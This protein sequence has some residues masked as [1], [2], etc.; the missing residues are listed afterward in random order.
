MV[1]RRV[2][3][4]CRIGVRQHERSPSPPA[5]RQSRSA[6]QG[7][8][9][10]SDL[11]GFAFGDP[12]GPPRIGRA[13]SFDSSRGGRVRRRTEHGGRG[14]RAARG[15]GLPSLPRR[16]RNA[17]RRHR[18]GAAVSPG[19]KDFPAVRLRPRA[20]N[21]TR[22]PFGALRPRTGDRQCRPGCAGSPAGC[23]P[24]GIA[25]PSGLSPSH[26]GTHP[27]PACTLAGARA[28]RVRRRRRRPWAAQRDRS[29][30]RSNA[31]RRLH[32]RTGRRDSGCASR[33][34]PLRTPAA[35][36]GRFG[37]DRGAGIRR[38]TGRAA[39]AR[40]SPT[41]PLRASSRSVRRSRS[42][43]AFCCSTGPNAP[44]PS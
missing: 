44:A 10:P 18:A 24:A 25:R 38:R 28:A 20:R 2:G 8:A 11:R 5:R 29:L 13:A 42:S 12:G 32:A 23:I 22:F 4:T 34:R 17:G 40:D 36:P 30:C 14:L 41:S 33:A 21:R 7:F 3:G 39:R 15:R 43:A 35:R 31:G 16:R 19:T 9:L 1:S 6:V 27:R 26:L 37:V